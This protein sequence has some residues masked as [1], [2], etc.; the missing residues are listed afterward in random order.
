MISEY[1]REQLDYKTIFA[2]V[3]LIAIGIVSIYSAAFDEVTTEQYYEKQLLWLYIGSVLMFVMMLLPY[4]LMPRIAI[5]AYAGSLFF[6]LVVLII[7]KTIAGSKSWLGFGGAGIQPSEFAKVGTILALAAY[8]SRSE[9]D[10]QKTKHLIIACAIVFIP[11]FLILLQPDAGT[12]MTFCGMF[13][14]VLVWGGASSFIMIFVCC[15]IGIAGA[16]LFGN[17]ALVIGI[18]LAILFIFSL[19]KDF[20]HSSI[21]AASVGFFGLTV[22]LVLQMLKPYQQKR[23]TSFLSPELDPLGSGYNVYQSKVAIGSGGLFGKGFLRGTQ[24]QFN[25]IP[26]QWTDFIFCVPGEEFGFIGSALVLGL[27]LW[28]LIRNINTAATI[29]NKFGS[30][31]VVGICALFFTHIVI[32]VGM[33]MGLFP[34]VGVPLPFLSYGGSALLANMMMVGLLLNMYAHRK[35]Y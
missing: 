11:V 31:V 15:C 18:C 4:K 16:A 1:F 19:R 33:A 25:F 28:L 26:E 35:V 7:G 5:A 10:L 20:F 9:T 23:L 24:T 17:T 21:A 30:V 32:N 14:P 22:Q 6:L 27:F 13:L 8:I 12:A 34:V 29:K 3:G 2:M